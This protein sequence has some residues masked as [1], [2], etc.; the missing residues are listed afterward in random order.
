MKRIILSLLAIAMINV[1]SSCGGSHQ[2]EDKVWFYKGDLVT[3]NDGVF[4]DI[5]SNNEKTY[6][7]N[8]DGTEIIF[9]DDTTV[10][11]Q[12]DDKTL[13]I[14]K[15]NSPDIKIF[16]IAQ[17]SDF[18]FGDW[19]GENEKG[20]TVYVEFNYSWGGDESLTVEIEDEKVIKSK[21]FKVDGNIIKLAGQEIEYELDGQDFLT[22]KFKDEE[23]ELIRD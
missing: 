23:I 12:V 21:S 14:K 4:K 13:R 5:I 22:I 7:F 19:E 11:V 16:R 1:L 3:F 20:E 8:D 2:V 6:S 17:E 18:L 9:G 10:I 15:K